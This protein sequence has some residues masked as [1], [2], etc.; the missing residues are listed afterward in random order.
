MSITNKL[1]WEQYGFGSTSHEHWLSCGHGICV[2]S[3]K[4]ELK[5]NMAS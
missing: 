2:S 4:T 5:N 1:M 3:E